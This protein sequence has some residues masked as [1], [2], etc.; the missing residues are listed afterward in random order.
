MIDH[1]I[2]LQ[3]LP[4]Y[5]G[6]KCLKLFSSYLSERSQKVFLNGH[7]SETGLVKY[8]V[9]Q[10]SVLGPVLFLL[11]VNDLPLSL[12][13]QT[14]Q[15]HMLADDTSLNISSKSL[16]E[17][18]NTLQNSITEIDKWCSKNH[19]VL[20]PNKTKSMLITTR[21]RHNRYNPKLNL[22]VNQIKIN[23]VQEH[24]LLGVVIDESLTWKQ[25]INHV[26]KKLSKNIYLL[27]RL[28]NI[29]DKDT[30][31]LFYN[32]FIKSHIDYCS[33]VW[34]NT[35][36]QNIQKLISLQRR[37]SKLIYGPDTLHTTDEKMRLLNIL[38]LKQQHELNKGILIHKTLSGQSPSYLKH[39]IK[40]SKQQ[41][42]RLIVPFPN[43]DY[44]KQSFSYSGPFQWN[45]I[46]KTV[47]K[48]KSLYIHV[49]K[50]SYKSFL[51]SK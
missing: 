33:T 24:K 15:C 17:I 49:F 14:I 43:L 2:L 13:S 22:S 50:K 6:D 36:K 42:S 38:P 4:L 19:M 32:A 20:N 37:A 45:K 12:S 29:L 25:H 30:K 35:S 39:I 46:P 44:F 9:P 31:I 26:S 47:I 5:L 7:L 8:G 51:L 3:K 34:D 28:K 41:N 27:N 1:T 48:T 11:Y 18:E 40:Q 16:P 23:Q 10:G 21:Q